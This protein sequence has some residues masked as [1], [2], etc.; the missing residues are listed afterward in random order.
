[1]KSNRPSLG[2]SYGPS[3][4]WNETVSVCATKWTN[5]M[6]VVATKENVRGLILC[7]VIEASHPNPEGGAKSLEVGLDL[8]VPP[9]HPSEAADLTVR[10]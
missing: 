2:P 5:T 1:M 6:L 7:L 3:A 8:E 9:L 4:Q 10:W